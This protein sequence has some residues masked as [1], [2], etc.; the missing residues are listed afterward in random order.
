MKCHL[1]EVRILP[2]MWLNMVDDY[3]LRERE[4]RV[5]AFSPERYRP[6]AVREEAPM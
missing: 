5:K 1:I 3:M 4:L 2:K 6:I